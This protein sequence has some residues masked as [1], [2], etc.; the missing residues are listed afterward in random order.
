MEAWS[1]DDL[2]AALDQGTD[3]FLKVYKSGCGICKM[4]EP[5]TRRMEEKNKHNLKFVSINSDDHPEIN[6]IAGVESYPTFYVFKQS[7]MKGS[8]IGFK[9]LAKLEAFVDEAVTS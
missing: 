1:T 8:F 3:I 5:A 7:K 6:E 4:S 2:K 9:G